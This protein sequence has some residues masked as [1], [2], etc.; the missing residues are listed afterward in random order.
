[1][2]ICSS[3]LLKSDLCAHV[4]SGKGGTCT[5]MIKVKQMKGVFASFSGP[6]TQ[7]GPAGGQ[8]KRGFRDKSRG[9]F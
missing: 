1:M 8:S 4:L 2:Q 6:E 7:S 5:M 3:C 9:A